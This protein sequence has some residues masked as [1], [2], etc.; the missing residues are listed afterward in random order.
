MASVARPID[1]RTMACGVLFAGVACLGCGGQHR[2][3]G[4]DSL[5]R[6]LAGAVPH[7]F[8]EPRTTLLER[9]SPCSF[10]SE[11]SDLIPEPVCPSLPPP[12]SKQRSRLLR[13]AARVRAT[14]AREGSARELHLLGLTQLI[15]EAPSDSAA[16][17]A[18]KT[19][20]RARVLES[21]SPALLSDLSAAYM[22]RAQRADRPLDLVK[23]L[24]LA[25]AALE[26]SPG[27]PTAL[28]N[29]AAVLTQ[30]HLR[31]AA[32]AAWD[33]YLSED[34]RSTWAREARRRRQELAASNI[35]DRWSGVRGE[36]SR[37]LS[38]GQVARLEELLEVDLVDGYAQ[39]VRTFVEEDGLGSWAD[40]LLADDEELANGSLVFVRRLAEEL[41]AMQGDTL[42]VD[43]TGAIAA[44]DA[45]GS[46]EL[47]RAHRL[48]RQARTLHESERYQEAGPLFEASA[49][50]FLSRGSPFAFW[51]LYYQAVLVHHSPDFAYALDLFKQL[52]ADR[53]FA[54]PIAHAYLD[55]MIGL[56]ELRSARFGRARQNFKEAHRGFVRA[57]EA[58]N[59]A[60]M[61]LQVGWAEAGL[62]NEEEA[63][64]GR[65]SALRELSRTIKH[66]RIINTLSAPARALDDR[67][68]P[69]ALY[70]HSELVDVARRSGSWLSQALALGRR[71][72]ALIARRRFVEAGRD[73]GE[74]RRVMKRIPAAGAR[75]DVEAEIDLLHSELLLAK[76]RPAEALEF[77]DRAASF[78]HLHNEGR[79]IIDAYRLRASAYESIGDEASAERALRAGLQEVERRRKLLQAD[80][81]R[82]NYLDKSRDLTEKLVA[83]LF[84]RGRVLDALEVLERSR[85]PLLRELLS[86]GQPDHYKNRT[87]SELV[88]EIPDDTVMVAYFVLSDRTF[89]WVLRSTSIEAS[90]IALGASALESTILRYHAAL[91]SSARALPEI[92]ST[93]REDLLQ[94]IPRVLND[95]NRVIFL[96]DGPLHSLSFGSL[97]S[98]GSGRALVE[99]RTVS[100]A[101]GVNAY[102]DLVASSPNAKGP[103]RSLLVVTNVLSD[104]SFP[105][106]AK[107]PSGGEGEGRVTTLLTGRNATTASLLANLPKHEVLYF[108]G[109]AVAI[110]GRSGARGLVL[111]LDSEEDDGVLTPDEIV[112]PV[113][114]VNRVAILA[115]CSTAA[116]DGSSTEGPIGLAWPLLASGVRS[117]VVSLQPIED[118]A[119]QS[120]VAAL[121]GGLA[122]GDPSPLLSA[123]R[124]SWRSGDRETP[125]A[126]VVVGEP[127]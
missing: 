68:S 8:F 34:D 120:F 79:M 19:L 126:F 38:L 43:A 114:H 47:A 15:L 5:W 103:P 102:L 33:L 56:S 89:V 44:S 18:V 85:A 14:A 13:I 1:L 118:A 64:R 123:S 37:A 11:G 95:V 31:S 80:D 73:I 90:E 9:W 54:Y 109:H 45:T 93:A 78:A 49:V 3:L 53:R 55:W 124:S 117:V 101:P 71:S 77:I 116:G 108:H 22:V 84:D 21:R 48:Y 65:Y 36:L 99:D 106:L 51:P 60:A 29:R 23:S 50:L 67:G 113:E 17:M 41:S 35:A 104:E 2:D 58:E 91:S 26:L 105:A 96:P 121:L 76:D 88:A 32:L 40:A 4:A 119:A 63:W 83:L 59:A 69:A 122:A 70:F 57:N 97:S 42:L 25:D 6:E 7:R 62:G 87:V 66:R 39:Q 75:S 12:E 125:A 27:E 115:G 52:K 28:F 16:D 107:L 24:E 86:R 98:P 92:G 112:L 10:D 81:D 110:P 72:R 127:L 94:L 100:I 82:R 30:L 74:S 61:A 20:E 111:A 46:A